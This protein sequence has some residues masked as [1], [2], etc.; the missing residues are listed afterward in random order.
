MMIKT[1]PITKHGTENKSWGMPSTK[2]TIFI[3][4]YHTISS[5][6]SEIIMEVGLKENER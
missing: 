2:C 1:E 6:Y 5:Q 3:T 4:I